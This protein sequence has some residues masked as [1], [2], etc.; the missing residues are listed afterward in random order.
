MRTPTLIFLIVFSL[1]ASAAFYFYTQD[2]TSTAIVAIDIFAALG[3]L[4]FAFVQVSLNRRLISLQDYVAM[5]VHAVDEGTAL[6]FINTGRLNMYMYRIEV[7]DTETNEL[8]G[9]TNVFEKPRLLPAGTLEQSYY[10]YPLSVEVFGHDRFQ[11][12]VFVTDEVGRK[13]VAEHGGEVLNEKE[14]RV[15]SHKME[16]EEWK[17]EEKEEE[18]EQ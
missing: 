6:Q 9:A 13:W 17:I 15:W 7:R 8:V 12:Y 2:V 18:E 4:S 10:W 5:V 16:K 1:V 14:V 11:V 3:V